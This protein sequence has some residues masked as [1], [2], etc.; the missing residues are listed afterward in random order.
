MTIEMQDENSRRSYWAEQMEEA[1][2]YIN[3]MRE[4]P[5]EECGEK[6]ISLRKAVKTARLTV[7][8]SDNKI[9]DKYE[10]LFYLREGLIK[11]FLAIA[12]ALNNRGWFIKVEDAFRTRSMQREIGKQCSVFNAIL[13]RVIWE[14]NGK[15]PSLDLFFS[16]FKN[17]IIPSPKAAAHMTGSALAVTVYHAGNLKPLYCGAKYQAISEMTMMNSPFISDEADEIRGEL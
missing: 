10:P 2:N 13:E 3:K 4:Y 11:K 5:V 7:K 16:R 1:A 17:F 14:N 8:F 9:S 6:M 15:L 12:K